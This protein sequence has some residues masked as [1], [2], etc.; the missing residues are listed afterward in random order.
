[1]TKI[2][3]PILKNTK[4]SEYKRFEKNLFLAAEA[5]IEANSS[6]YEELKINGECVVIINW[7]LGKRV[8]R[9]GRIFFCNSKCK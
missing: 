9:I 1:M 6:N 5:Y 4:D 2:M 8:V 7:I 3:N